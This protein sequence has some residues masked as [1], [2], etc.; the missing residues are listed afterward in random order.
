M[1]LSH[2]APFVRVSEEK[3]REKFKHLYDICDKEVVDELILNELKAEIKDSVQT[4]NYQISTLQ[5][6]NGQSPFVSLCIYLNEEPEYIK[7]TALLAEE[8]FNQRIEGMENEY[9]VKATQTFPY[10]LGA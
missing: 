4:F 6:T 2:I 9:G 7:E 10:R 3:I 8:F 1:A 5:T